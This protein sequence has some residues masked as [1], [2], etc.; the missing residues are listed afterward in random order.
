MP[1]CLDVFIPRS[2]VYASCL[3]SAL[4]LPGFGLISTPFLVPVRLF[5]FI[6]DVCLIL[7]ASVAPD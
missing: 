4:F 5:M 1:E 7:A 3:I 2:F 6:R